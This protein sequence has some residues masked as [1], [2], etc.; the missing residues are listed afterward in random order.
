MMTMNHP[1][2]LLHDSSSSGF[3]VRRLIGSSSAVLYDAFLLLLL[4]LGDIVS[5]PS[6]SSAGAASS[7][8]SGVLSKKDITRS[9][10][11]A[12]FCLLR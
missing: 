12:L 5:E 4:M 1:L 8:L 6:I 10:F 7:V 3:V 9:F 11:L 2:L